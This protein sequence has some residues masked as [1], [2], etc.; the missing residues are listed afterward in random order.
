MT[1]SKRA[2]IVGL[3]AYLPEK[4]LSN[5]DL[6]HMV[7][8][9][10]EWITSRTGIKERRIAAAEETCS[11]MAAMA[12]KEAL[13]S[14]NCTIEEVDLILLAT[15]SPDYLCPGASPLV[16]EALGASSIP[17]FD[18]HAACTGYIYGLSAAK[19]WIESGMYHKILLIASEK[20]SYLIDYQDRNTCILFG[21]GAAACVV[22]A[23]GKGLLLEKIS[24]GADGKQSDLIIVKE[25]G[26]VAPFSEN[27]CENRGQFVQMS[28]KEVFKHAVRR[29]AH[30]AKELLKEANLSENEIK[31]LVPHQ[32]NIRIIESIAKSCSISL[33]SVYQTLEKYGNT[34]ASSVGIALEELCQKH[35][36]QEGDRVLLVAFGAGLTWG[37]ALLKEIDS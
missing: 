7:D 25:G 37:S 6:E 35:P 30:S 26:S 2:R 14:A 23:E 8:T 21:D 4:I 16:Q 10:D 17:C 28:G 18:I 19:A 32:A 20:M 12:A 36:L 13:K 3:G 34:S 31:W 24:L 15:M 11:S 33:S 1:V 27:T 9:S 29:M 5:R 22:S